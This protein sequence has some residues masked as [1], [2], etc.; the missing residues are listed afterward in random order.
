M[1]MVDRSIG[2]LFSTETKEIDPGVDKGEFGLPAAV[3]DIPSVGTKRKR[4]AKGGKDDGKEE[5]EKISDAIMACATAMSEGMEK[6]SNNLVTIGEYIRP[7]PTIVEG[8]NWRL[9]AQIESKIAMLESKVNMTAGDENK[10]AR[11]R[12]LLEK[13]EREAYGGV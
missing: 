12:V 7:D 11:L 8:E 5:S 1:Y 10:L 6:F 9:M 4:S 3:A 13:K 2:Y